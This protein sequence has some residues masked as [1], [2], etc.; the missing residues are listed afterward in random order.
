[1]TAWRKVCCCL[2]VALCGG[3]VLFG[4]EIDVPDLLRVSFD[5]TSG[6]ITVPASAVTAPARLVLEW[7]EGQS[8][9]V[10]EKV[11]LADGVYPFDPQALGISAGEAVTAKL[12]TRFDMLDFIQSTGTQYF[13][14]D[15]VITPTM[16]VE[17]DAQL[18]EMEQQARIFG[19]TRDTGAPDATGYMSFGVYVTGGTTWGSALVD[20]GGVWVNSGKAADTDRHVH[21]LDCTNLKT[22]YFLDGVGS[23][24]RSAPKLSTCGSLYLFAEHRDP[25][26]GFAKMKLFGCTITDNAA[27]VRKFAPARSGGTASLYDFVTAEFLTGGGEDAFGMGEVTLP[28]GSV[29]AKGSVVSFAFGDFACTVTVPAPLVT[30]PMM[31]ELRWGDGNREVL[32]AELPRTGGTYTFYPELLGIENGENVT[33]CLVTRY[34]L[35]ESIESKGTQYLDTGVVITPTMAVEADAQLTEVGKQMRIFANTHGTSESPARLS[36][37]VYVNGNGQW[38]SAIKDDVGDWVAS[39]VAADTARH[40]HKLDCVT[41]KYYLDGKERGTQHA[42]VAQTSTPGTLFLFAENRFPVWNYA[43]GFAKAKIF[44]CTIFD[45][46]EAIR[47]L[48]PARKDGVVGLYDFVTDAFLPGAGTGAEGLTAGEVTSA[49]GS[50]AVSVAAACARQIVDPQPAGQATVSFGEPSVGSH[51]VKLPVKVYCESG[52]SVDVALAFAQAGGEAFET[53]LVKSGAVNGEVFLA[54]LNGLSPAQDYVIRPVVVGKTVTGADLAVHT[55]ASEPEPFGGP[56]ILIDGDPNAGEPLT[57]RFEAPGRAVSLYCLTGDEDCGAEPAGWP[58][59]TKVADIAANQTSVVVSRPDGWGTAVNAARYYF[60]TTDDRDKDA[61][62]A[63]YATAE[64]GAIFGEWDALNNAG[65]GVFDPDALGLKDLRGNA[66]L[67]VVQSDKKYERMFTDGRTIQLKGVAY[68]EGHSAP[69]RDRL[70][71]KSFTLEIYCRLNGSASKDHGGLVDF[72]N[73]GTERT[74]DFDLREESGNHAALQYLQNGWGN[75]G[76][77][78]FVGEPIPYN[79]YLHF[80]IVGNPDDGLIRLYMNGQL[81]KERAAGNNGGVITPTAD[82]LWIG[83]YGSSPLKVNIAAMRLHDRPLAAAE[84]DN[85]RALDER[86]YLQMTDGVVRG[87]LALSAPVFYQASDV[88]A[89]TTVVPDVRYGDKAVISG[90]FDGSADAVSVACW[91][92]G[93]A[94]TQEVAGVLSGKT[95]SATLDPLEPGVVHGYCVTLS[96]SVSARS[97]GTFRTPAACAVLLQ[98]ATPENARWGA[99]FS[100]GTQGA[101]DTFVWAE[102]KTGDGEYR[103]ISDMLCVPYGDSETHGLEAFSPWVDC[104]VHFRLAVSNAC[105]RVQNGSWVT[106]TDER[107]AKVTDSTGYSFVPNGYGVISDAANWAPNTT[108]GLGYPKSEKCEIAIRDNWTSRLGID[109]AYSFGVMRIAGV[110]RTIALTGT[111]ENA[112]FN[113][114]ITGGGMHNVSLVLSN[115]QVKEDNGIS[116]GDPSTAQLYGQS[117]SNLVWIQRGATFWLPVDGMTMTSSR[118]SELRISDDGRFELERLSLVCGEEGALVRFQG[119]SPAL[120]ASYIGLSPGA[121]EKWYHSTMDG[122]V[123]F[124]FEVPENGYEVAP[125]ALSGTAETAR[126]GRLPEGSKGKYVV[127]VASDSPAFV[128]RSRLTVPLLTC[129]AGIETENVV[130]AP[131]TEKNKVTYIYTYGPEANLKEPQNLGDLPTGIR[132]RLTRQSGLV[133]MIR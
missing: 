39:E 8:A 124:R 27:P 67:S 77:L 66:D 87:A 132:A 22:T 128:S 23:A 59:A 112:S 5:A 81:I 113:G 28:A 16:A 103:R 122:D 35:L 54:A 96:G 44:G 63:A 14:T 55:P 106:L 68:L 121:G 2:A 45:G 10:A 50:V 60:S 32:A 70:A 40:V 120:V 47:R 117:Y 109:G 85:N 95:F 89:I 119:D 83:K 74:L 99:V 111:V 92:E 58:T 107:Q 94:T 90:T 25:P 123:V 79:D 98:S 36:F 133:L 29:I 116:L 110:D 80:A 24:P 53:V 130:F 100:I 108:T 57:L 21:K 13:D 43:E 6:S 105:S 84:I 102:M 101:G 62:R 12:V 20:N 118:F 19:N 88:P 76:S 65:D 91:Q 37:G 71:A 69:F 31:L 126:F 86:R 115:I 9:V 52:A 75:D 38:A 82:R 11:P 129:A 125:V 78:C 33:A 42:S 49:A 7:G 51:H 127:E 73:S 114:N 93:G 4:E 34:D 41:C 46:G 56:E 15:V 26:T 17:A 48:V 61:W 3:A 1:M 72:G 30:Q 97:A 131:S 18:T 64:D 104:T